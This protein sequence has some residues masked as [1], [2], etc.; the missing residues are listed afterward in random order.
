MKRQTP[1][2]YKMTEID[3]VKWNYKELDANHPERIRI[4][5][6]FSRIQPLSAQKQLETTAPQRMI[7]RYTKKG[8]EA[9]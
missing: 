2:T 9:I 8:G 3:S 6:I 5:Q 4:E 1:F 7:N